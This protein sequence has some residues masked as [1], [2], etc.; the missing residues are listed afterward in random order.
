MDKAS[1]IV[2]TYV[3][4]F[5]SADGQITSVLPQGIDLPPVPIEPVTASEEESQNE[6]AGS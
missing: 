5:D 1:N 6:N 2:D 4:P 3:I